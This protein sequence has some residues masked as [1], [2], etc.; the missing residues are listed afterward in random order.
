[1]W[2]ALSLHISLALYHRRCFTSRL[3]FSFPFSTPGISGLLGVWRCWRAYRQ[4]EG[5]IQAVTRANSFRAGL[6]VSN[7][8]LLFVWLAIRC[9]AVECAR[10][11]DLHELSF[12]TKRT[13]GRAFSP[14]STNTHGC[15][16]RF[17]R[18]GDST[19]LLKFGENSFHP[20]HT[21]PYDGILMSMFIFSA[22]HQDFPSRHD[23]GKNT[24]PVIG[25]AWDSC[26]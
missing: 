4:G 23:F 16:A 13:A 14:R 11:R 24:L 12:L 6:W 17:V 9:A 19:K 15:F 10:S 7:V 20:G 8:S 21:G 25:R 5:E 3:G 26:V 18:P 2:V 22:S 1:M